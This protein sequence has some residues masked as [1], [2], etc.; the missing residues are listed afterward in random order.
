MSFLFCSAIDTRAPLFAGGSRADQ[1]DRSGHY[2]KWEDDFALAHHL[3]VSALYYGPA[4]YRAHLAPDRYDW[5]T[6]AEPMERLRLLGLGTGVLPH[7]DEV[8]LLRHRSGCLPAAGQD[9]FL[10]LVP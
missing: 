4:Y 5:E 2:A 3:G 6:C 8:R 9:R 1:M 10:G 7:H